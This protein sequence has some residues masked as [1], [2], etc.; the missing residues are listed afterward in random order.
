MLIKKSVLCFL[1]LIIT[2]GWPKAAE[3][4]YPVLDSRCPEEQFQRYVRSLENT[5]SAIASS[6]PGYGSNEY[7]ELNFSINALAL[8]GERSVPILLEILDKYPSVVVNE[9]LYTTMGMGS[10]ASSA[11]SAIFE[12][13]KSNEVESFSKLQAARALSSIGAD[14]EEITSEVISILEA[15]GLSEEFYRIGFLEILR[16]NDED[17]YSTGK[18]IDFIEQGGY[19]GTVASSLAIGLSPAIDS[20]SIARLVNLLKTESDYQSVGS[21]FAL[22]AFQDYSKTSASHLERALYDSKEFVT[23]IGAVTALSSLGEVTQDHIDHYFRFVILPHKDEINWLYSTYDLLSLND[24]LMENFAIRAEHLL[25]EIIAATN[26]E[27]IILTSSDDYSWRNHDKF[28]ARYSAFFIL[29]SMGNVASPAVENLVAIVSDETDDY[30]MRNVAIR[31]LG[32]IGFDASAAIPKLKGLLENDEFASSA[33]EA[34]AKMGEFEVA[35]PYF[36]NLIYKNATAG[37]SYFYSRQVLTEIGSPSISFLL[38]DFFAQEDQP[39]KQLYLLEVL[40]EIAKSSKFTDRQIETLVSI[41]NDEGLDF[42]IR[43]TSAYIL[44]R[45]GIDVSG[46]YVANNL[47]PLE[48]ITCPPEVVWQEYEIVG[49]VLNLIDQKCESVGKGNGGADLFY[50]IRNLFARR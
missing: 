6:S 15:G 17:K 11:S 41:L 48:Y 10:K 1:T 29:S 37:H 24:L 25:P 35:I 4:N 13:L 47:I 39:E 28:R 33:A 9:V 23:K 12:V 38:N 19:W 26:K 18:L 32:S 8:C 5:A 22:A 42:N 46:F 3:A 20:E 21:A 34:L 27:N 40:L 14:P 2:A 31:A 43:R 7:G 16:I 30:G 45:I 49:Y 44:D 50:R 36:I